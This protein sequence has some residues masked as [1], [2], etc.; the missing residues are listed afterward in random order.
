MNVAADVAGRYA[1]RPQNR[2]HQVREIL[3]D[4]LALFQHVVHR[5]TRQR[6]VAGVFKVIVDV[7][8]TRSTNSPSGVPE[9]GRTASSIGARRGD[10][11]TGPRNWMKSSTS[12]PN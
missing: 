5:R 8:A 1:E 11:R 7:S 4:A 2:D 12:N 10:G 6:H 3:A 9:R